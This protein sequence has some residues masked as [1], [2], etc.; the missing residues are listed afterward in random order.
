MWELEASS[1]SFCPTYYMLDGYKL[2]L[3]MTVVYHS[4]EQIFLIN[5]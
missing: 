3:N 4:F 5:G 1:V 2:G